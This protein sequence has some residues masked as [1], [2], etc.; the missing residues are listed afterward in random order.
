[1]AMLHLSLQ[2]TCTA[3]PAQPTSQ[4]IVATCSTRRTPTGLT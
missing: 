1:M 4:T 2:S 3:Q